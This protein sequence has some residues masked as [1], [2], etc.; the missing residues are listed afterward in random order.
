MAPPTRNCRFGNSDREVIL[1]R[2]LSYPHAHQHYLTVMLGISRPTALVSSATTLTMDG[3]LD[4]S[5]ASG[6]QDAPQK[7]F[8]PTARSQ[9][10]TNTVATA[11]FWR[12]RV[13]MKFPIGLVSQRETLA[14]AALHDTFS[15][16]SFQP[17][18]SHRVRMGLA[19][20]SGQCRGR[21]HPVMLPTTMLCYCGFRG[22]SF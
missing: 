2:H 7:T 11:K 1:E 12:S 20:L 17:Y 6:V 13:L 10:C 5:R 16:N 3:R 14:Q 9:Q 22:G 18:S 19:S 8:R 4:N 21:A 15:S